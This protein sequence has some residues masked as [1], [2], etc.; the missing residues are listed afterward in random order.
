MEKKITKK[1]R[2]VQLLAINE[3]AV[4][5]D[6]VDFINHEIEHL[7]KK[8]AKSGSSKTQ[9]ENTE[10]KAMLLAELVK[11][12]KAVTVTEFMKASDYVGE[13]SNQK[14]SALLKQLVEAGEVK[15][16]TDKGKSYF[17]AIVDTVDADTDTDVDADTD[18][19]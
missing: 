17:S 7:N 4:N 10:I 5:K 8:S 6:L 2:F 14:I 15:K 19:D 18:V 3:V 1:D 9:K 12:G 16:T 13:Y 11:I